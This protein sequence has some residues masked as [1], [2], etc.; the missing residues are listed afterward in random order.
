MK[1]AFVL[2]LICFISIP[3]FAQD[4]FQFQSNKN[5]VVI[6]FQLINNL[7]FI[8][9][10]VNGVELN[11][12]LDTGVDETILFSLEDKDEVRFFNVEKIKLKGLGDEDAIEGL[13]SSHNKL[14]LPHMLDADHELFIVLDQ[15]FNFSSH[16]G[17]PVNG[18]IGYHFFK[19]NLVEIDYDR[20]KVFVYKENKKVSKRI[21]NKYTSYPISIENN[22]P[23][24]FASVDIIKK[25]V[26]VK[27]LLDSGNSDAI[28]LFE[29]RANKIGVPAKNFNDF[30]GRGFNGDIYGKR[31]RV[32][33][34]AIDQFRFENPIVA[35]PNTSSLGNVVFVKDRAGSIG[36][37]IFKRFSVIFDY[38]NS[39]LYL[40]RGRNFDAPFNYNMSGV[41]IQHQGLQWVQE[42]V[43][44]QTAP[45]GIEFD[46]SGERIKNDFKYKFSLKPIYSISNVRKDSPAD[47]SGL[48]KGDVVISI[49]KSPSYK[50]SLEQ[51]TALLK[52]EDGKTIEME[53]ERNN[54]LMKFK[55]QLKSM[56]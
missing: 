42:T 1:K 2:I 50:Y 41:E 7:I 25:T 8:P 21:K 48:K 30:L 32:A 4:G 35:F 19:N 45:K 31:A 14:E 37:E 38:K 29:N 17:I 16:V 20:K 28:W 13:K 44:L 40:K 23:Y 18:I 49:N 52:S 51:I 55:F 43:Q 27:L 36:G 54:V 24:L 46:S 6:P 53:V 56:L 26:P 5:K 22:K 11:F 3:L 34:F 33:N 9:I 10:K 47:L 12:L 39:S 15:D